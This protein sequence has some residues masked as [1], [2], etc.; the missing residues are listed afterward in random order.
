[1]GLAS[2]RFGRSL[3]LVP[4]YC[5]STGVLPFFSPSR[6]KNRDDAEATSRHVG[7]G[8]RLRLRVNESASEG[9]ESKKSLAVRPAHAEQDPAAQR[10]PAAS[11]ETVPDLLDSF[12]VNDRGAMNP[13]EFPRI[14]SRFDLRRRRVIRVLVAPDVKND[15]IARRLNPIDVA[16][17]NKEARF[18]LSY[19]EPLGEDPLSLE[20]L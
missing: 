20:N 10:H 7:A 14:Q 11:R 9:H 16:R 13:Q 6:S 8:A 5:G 1:V 12:D 2:G 17:A 15:V 4:P 19:Q 18:P 3:R